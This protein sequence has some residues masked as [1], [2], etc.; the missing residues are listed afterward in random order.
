MNTCYGLGHWDFNGD[1]DG[2]GQEWGGKMGACGS[3]KTH[4][5]KCFLVKI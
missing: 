4:L 5:R 3:G 2:G 1:Q